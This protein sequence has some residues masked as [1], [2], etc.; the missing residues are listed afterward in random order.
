MEKINALCYLLEELYP[1]KLFVDDESGNHKIDQ[2]EDSTFP[3]HVSITIVSGEFSNLSMI[4]RQRLVN[5]VLET[6]YDNGLKFAK[7]EAYT[8]KEF[9]LKNELVFQH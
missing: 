7:I 8:P 9:E 3:S 4:A 5:K 6:A 2:R 1:Y